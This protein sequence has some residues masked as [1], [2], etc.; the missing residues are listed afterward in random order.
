MTPEGW[1]AVKLGD[2]MTATIGGGT[3]DRSNVDY[4][5]G[6]IPWATVKDF[7]P[8]VL[9]ETQEHITEEGLRNSASNLVPANTVVV[10]TRM[11]VGAVF[12]SGVP[13]AI[14]QDLR[15][16]VPAQTLSADYFFYFLQTSSRALCRLAAGTT[17]KG[18]RV[19]T[20][21][22]LFLPLP[23]LPEQRKIAAILSS[24]DDAIEKTQA[25]IDQVQVVKR[26]L[27]QE[28]LLRGLPGRHTRFKQTEIGE[29]PEEW[30]VR[31]LV[32]CCN[33]KGQYGANVAKADFK[34]G[35]IRYI[36][37]TD[38]DDNGALRDNAVGIS[39]ENT[40]GYLLQ[41]GDILFARSGATVGK[42]YMHRDPGM[43]SAFAGYL[44]RFRTKRDVLL[45]TFLREYLNTDVY[46][47]WVGDRQHAQAQPNINAT[48]YGQLPVP[49]APLDEQRRVME[50][51]ES[52]NSS[53]LRARAEVLG[54]QWLKRALMPVLLT[55]ELRVT[56]GPEVA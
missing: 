53:L 35:G 38:I 30:E 12:R 54:K 1:Q 14:N 19:N 29:I 32:D 17:V 4:W 11:N 48:E 24:L 7:G 21:R 13:I 39:G 51:A 43:R 9:S 31:A 37:I 36:R 15:A 44:V 2:V 16:L 46:W 47:R 49:C 27:M 55:G 45:P 8:R 56:P 26:G 20:L 41:L 25:V 42:A 34:P 6:S 5:G 33:G 52:F 50:I 3:P 40:D 18:L 10:A 28:L 23:P 22:S